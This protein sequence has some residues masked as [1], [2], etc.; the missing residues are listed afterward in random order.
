VT[1]VVDAH[2]DVARERHRECAGQ[3]HGHGPP[4]R[5]QRDEGIDLGEP[6]RRFAQRTRG[7]QPGPARH[8]RRVDH[9]NLNVARQPV[10][11]QTV[12]GEDRR[13]PDAG[14]QRGRRLRGPG[15]DDGCPRASGSGSSPTRSDRVDGDRIGTRRRS[16]ARN[17]GRRCPGVAALGERGE[18]RD[19]WRLSLPPTV[20]LPTMTTGATAAP[21][22]MPRR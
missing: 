8:A 5:H 11:L 19:E 2:E 13:I 6:R 9:G 4:R 22:A 16:R 17:P 12:I 21:D 3:A 1:R 20:M 18:R 7:Q 10:V 15:D 14:E